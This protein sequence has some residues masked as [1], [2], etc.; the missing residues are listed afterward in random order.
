MMSY[1]DGKAHESRSRTFAVEW[2]LAVTCDLRHQRSV[3]GVLFIMRQIGNAS[4]MSFLDGVPPNNPGKDRTSGSFVNNMNL[5][6]HRWFR[7]SGGFSAEWVGSLI[8]AESKYRDVSVFDPFAGSGTTLITA[9]QFGVPAVGT[10]SHPFVA[11]VARAKLAYRSDPEE[12][13]ALARRVE[14]SARYR[15]PELHGYAGLIRRCYTDETLAELDCLRQSVAD[16]ENCSESGSLVWL[17]LVSILR[18]TSHVGTANWQYV[19][20]SHRK[21]RP[22]SPFAAFSDMANK[23]YEDMQL[24]RSLNGPRATFNEDDARACATIPDDSCNLVITSPPYPNNY[25]YAD[26]TRLELT[27]FGEVHRWGDLQH[28]I[29]RHLLRSCTQHVPDKD[30]DYLGVLKSPE[31][32]PI[33]PSLS[34]VCR[35]LDWVRKGRGGRKTYHNMV[36]CYFLD[37][38]KVWIALRRVCQTPSNLCFVIGDSA[39][40][41]VYVPVIDWLGQL[42]VAAGFTSYRFEKIRDR[43]TK[44]ANRKHRVP[45]CEGRLWIEG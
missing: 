17:A 6:I 24:S 25:D 36:A 34:A 40:Y 41:G 23:M 3:Y 5:P 14:E 9:E 26:A 21:A 22:D 1:E 10:D 13:L 11:R 28:K 16:F 43:N 37:L 2:S 39:P 12:F 18:R 33:L 19:L 27:F 35:E 4:Q 38:A 30:V 7:Y 42:A 44:W 31:L 8:V 45:L 15:Q 29:R 32:E 20:P